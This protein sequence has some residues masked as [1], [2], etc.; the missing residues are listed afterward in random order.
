MSKTSQSTPGNLKK[1][2]RFEGVM[3]GEKE[4]A[5]VNNFELL[6]EVPEDS[7]TV[8]NVSGVYNLKQVSIY[9]PIL[10]YAHNRVTPF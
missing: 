5:G 4:H 10:F 1:S 3:S 6:Q 7:T 8:Q 2:L 9:D